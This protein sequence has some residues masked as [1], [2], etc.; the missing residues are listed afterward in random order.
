[1]HS[2]PHLP[3]KTCP[4]CDRPFSWRKK[5]R[6]CWTEVIYCSKRCRSN[7]PQQT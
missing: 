2:K 1:M 5:W 6:N 4:V 7:K 3:Y